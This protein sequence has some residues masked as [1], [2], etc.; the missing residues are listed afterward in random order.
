AS[1]AATTATGRTSLSWS[2][3]IGAGT[4]R[5]LVVGVA[6][7]D[8]TTA[9]ANVTSVTYNGVALTAV[10]NS[11]R[12]GGGAGI[13][14]TQLFFLVGSTVPAAGAHTV[15]VTFQGP[16]D[17]S[18]AGAIS[19]F[20]VSQTAPQSVATNVDTSGADSI[21]TSIA[22]VTAGAWVVDVVGSGNSGSF[23]A[24]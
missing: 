17:G 11:K 14:Q 1:R 19:L 16:V 6:V 5:A 2:H 15:T 8:A 22:N 18:S 4:D 20:G 21:S 3:T 7:E 12:S 13:I 9:D 10:P 23:T 24:A